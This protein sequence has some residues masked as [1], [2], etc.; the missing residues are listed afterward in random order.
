MKFFYMYVG[1]K[2]AAFWD[3]FTAVTMMKSLLGYCIL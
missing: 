1:L 3:V 2:T